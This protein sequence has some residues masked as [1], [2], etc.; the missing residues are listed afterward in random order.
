MLLLTAGIALWCVTHLLPSAA[1][2][3]RGALVARFGEGPYR[4][5]FSLLILAS[6]V[7]IVFGWKSTSSTTLYAAPL[8][9][10]PLPSLL[11]LLGFALF[12]VSKTQS[13]VKR[14]LRHPQMTG[15]FLWSVAHLLTN[16]DSRSVALFG[17]FAAWSLLEIVLI[18]RRD[19]KRTQ[20][21]EATA[22]GDVTALV[23]AVVAFALLGYL[24]VRLFGVAAMP[25]P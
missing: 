16:G 8:T 7:M 19:G 10:G 25:A 5:I 21:P 2:T 4:G 14:I 17:S 18:N 12:F 24:H 11:V 23:L 15:V 22:K 1:P 3:Q 13:H 20:L 6:L 9:A